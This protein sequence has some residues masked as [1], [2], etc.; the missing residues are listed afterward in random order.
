MRLTTLTFSSLLL[1]SLVLTGC[2]PEQIAA[3]NPEKKTKEVK[4]EAPKVKEGRELA[5]FGAGCFWCI[6]AALDQL[7]GVGRTQNS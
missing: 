1:V 3:A 7:E 5:T 6:E 2:F 4:T